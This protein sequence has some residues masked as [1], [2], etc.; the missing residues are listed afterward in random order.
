ME[1]LFVFKETVLLLLIWCVLQ[2][3][4]IETFSSLCPILHP[5]FQSC[6]WYFGYSGGSKRPVLN[7]LNLVQKARHSVCYLPWYSGRLW[8][9][10]R[11][12]KSAYDFMDPWM[13]TKNCTIW[14]LSL[15][16]QEDLKLL[17]QKLTGLKYKVKESKPLRAKEKRGRGGLKKCLQ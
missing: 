8:D 10:S 7:D 6:T 3:C 1:E 13:F 4:Q 14:V 5:N 12:R 9:H 16:F 17:I 2:I 15:V 11:R